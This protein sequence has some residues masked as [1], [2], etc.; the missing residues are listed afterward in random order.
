M[1]ISTIKRFFGSFIVSLILIFM[2]A[3]LFIPFGWVGMLIFYLFGGVPLSIILSVVIGI[4]WSVLIYPGL[5]IGITIPLVIL[6]ILIYLFISTPLHFIGQSSSFIWGG[7]E[8]S[9]NNLTKKKKKIIEEHDHK[10]DETD[11]VTRPK[12]QYVLVFLFFALGLIYVVGVDVSTFTAM[13]QDATIITVPLIFLPLVLTIFVSGIAL[14]L[15]GVSFSSEAPSNQDRIDRVDQASNVAENA[16]GI[17]SDLDHINE[18]KEAIKDGGKALKNSRHAQRAKQVGQAADTAVENRGLM[19]IGSKLR[20]IPKIGP[21]LS[22][23]LA[24]TAGGSAIAVLL[25][26]LI[27][28]L[29]VWGIVA[30]ILWGGVYLLFRFIFAPF[31]GEAFGVATGFGADVGGA[32]G[33]GPSASLNTPSGVSNSINLATARVSCMLQG[34]ECMQEWRA[35]NTERPGSEDVGREFGLEIESFNVNSDQ[36]LDISTRRQSDNI[37]VQFDVYNPIQGLKGVEARDVQYR[38]AIDGGP[39]TNCVTEWRD[40]GG[41]FLGSGDNAIS[42]GGFA[43][44]TGDLEDLTLKNCGALHPGYSQSMNAELQIKYDYSSQSTLQFQAMAEDYMIDQEIR[45]EPTKSQ[46]ANTPVKAFVNVQSPVVFRD[47]PDG[48][49]PTTFPVWFGFETEGFNLEY[50][51]EP[52]DFKIYGSSLLTDVSRTEP[53]DYNL[54]VTEDEFGGSCNDLTYQGN[55]QYNLSSSYAQNIEDNQEDGNWYTRSLGPTDARCTMILDNETLN[56]VSPTGESMSIRVD[57]NY[58][59]TLSSETTSFEVTNNRCNSGQINCPLIV[60]NSD[61]E[62]GNI[63]STCDT[64]TDIQSTDGCTVIENTDAWASIPSIINE[65]SKL[66]E[67]ISNRETAYRLSTLIN[68]ITGEEPPGES[69]FTTYDNGYNRSLV[70]GIEDMPSERTGG[71]GG[72]IVYRNSDREVEVSEVENSFCRGKSTEGERISYLAEENRIDSREDV[73]FATYVVQEYGL[74]DRYFDS[75]PGIDIC[76]LDEN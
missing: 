68:N 75:Y 40:L 6:R 12:I 72:W 58:T 11:Q 28:L 69:E 14:K 38:V 55:D 27:V 56:S 43:R 33:S 52:E 76:P 19:R 17:Y 32:V 22:D 47:T 9:V 3:Y 21:W 1:I 7:F 39:T 53:D 25:V 15:Q 63:S 10:E 74:L 36:T 30:L 65:N 24:G 37:P 35:N 49:Q 61:N 16:V 60:P 13:M 46:T 8:A 71:D 64:A 42:P 44:P 48:R 54:D 23:I 51:V 70:A 41:Q 34:P 62:D 2:L 20:A 5:K 57:A 4:T 50:N 26:V 31:L 66:S 18:K 45:P 67:D 73:I 29:I 59:V